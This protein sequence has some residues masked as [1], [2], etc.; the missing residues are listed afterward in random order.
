MTCVPRSPFRMPTLVWKGRHPAPAHRIRKEMGSV[1]TFFLPLPF[2]LYFDGPSRGN[3]TE[4]DRASSP[5]SQA[6]P[7]SARDGGPGGTKKEKRSS[8]Y[9]CHTPSSMLKVQ[10]SDSRGEKDGVDRVAG[11]SARTSEKSLVKIRAPGVS[12]P[13]NQNGAPRQRGGPREPFLALRQLTP[14]LLPV[15]LASI[16]L[17]AFPRRYLVDISGGHVRERRGSRER[18]HERFARTSDGCN[19]DLLGTCA[20]FWI[21]TPTR[22]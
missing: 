21:H 11:Q 13:P 3:G 2:S 7:S 9:A 18:G 1:E 20:P 10:S 8:F 15:S 16:L 6:S 5:S 14:I 17:D 12:Q 4:G 19:T 22:S